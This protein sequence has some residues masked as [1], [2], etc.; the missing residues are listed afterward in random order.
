MKA[1][2]C[3]YCS[4]CGDLLIVKIERVGFDRKTGEEIKHKH[5]YCPNGRWWNSHDNFHFDASDDLIIDYEF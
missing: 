2:D 1:E 4:T 3:N 5:I